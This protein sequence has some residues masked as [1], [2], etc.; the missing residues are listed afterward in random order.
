MSDHTHSYLTF[1]ICIP[2][3][4]S[5]QLRIESQG[6]SKVHWTKHRQIKS[7]AHAGDR[8]HFKGEERYYTVASRL[9]YSEDAGNS[10][11][12]IDYILKHTHH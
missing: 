7:S 12:L 1:V 5:I 11:E 10:I 2:L 8:E 3:M 4:C 6:E 9:L